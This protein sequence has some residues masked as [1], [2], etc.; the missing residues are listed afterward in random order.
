MC[1]GPGAG[2][3]SEAQGCGT[4]Q[5]D[6]HHQGPGG[7]GAACSHADERD[8]EHAGPAHDSE[9][10]AGGAGEDPGAGELHDLGAESGWRCGEA[11]AR[12]GEEASSGCVSQ[13]L[14]WTVW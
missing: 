4:G 13:S 9:H 11:D 8:S 6:G 7:G 5:G 3:V 2:A 1:C 12:T 14:S 10:D